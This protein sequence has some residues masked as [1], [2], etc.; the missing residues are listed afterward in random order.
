MAPNNMNMNMYGMG[1]HQRQQNVNMQGQNFFVPG[2]MQNF[3]SN[4]QAEVSLKK[5]SLERNQGYIEMRFKKVLKRTECFEGPFPEWNET[6]DFK[7]NLKNES[8]SLEKVFTN[9][10]KSL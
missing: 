5:E 1:F 4:R 8:M 10:E 7:Y 3:G 6:L 2:M 9:N